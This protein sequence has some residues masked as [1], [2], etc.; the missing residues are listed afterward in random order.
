MLYCSSDINLGFLALLFI[1]LLSFLG[2]R[3]VLAV[4]AVA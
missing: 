3:V 2:L 4:V 1:L